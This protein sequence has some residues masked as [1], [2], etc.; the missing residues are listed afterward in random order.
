MEVTGVALRESKNVGIFDS[1][2]VYRGVVVG[3]FE[4][5]DDS[6]AEFEGLFD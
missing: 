6:L 1:L 3:D 2:F 4:E 5:L